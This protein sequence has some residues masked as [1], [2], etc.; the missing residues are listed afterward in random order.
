MTRTPLAAKNKQPLLAPYL[1]AE[2]KLCARG[3]LTAFHL[4]E[5]EDEP[6]GSDDGRH[7]PDG[8]YFPLSQVVIKSCAAP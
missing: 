5:Q 8:N 4:Q 7:D 3:C 1:E 2:T 6:I